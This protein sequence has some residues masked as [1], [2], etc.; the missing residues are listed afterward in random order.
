MLPLSKQEDFYV[1][2]AKKA[3]EEIAKSLQESDGKE[4]ESALPDDSTMTSSE[5]SDASSG[6]ES[7]FEE[8]SLKEGEMEEEPNASANE[9]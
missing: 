9:I 4:N 1:E 2:E 6:S 8:L 3:K 7:S 5:G